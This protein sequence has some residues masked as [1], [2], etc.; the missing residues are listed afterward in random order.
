MTK[1]RKLSLHENFISTRTKITRLVQMLK[2]CF[3][4]EQT[5]E[6]IYTYS[7]SLATI[8]NRSDTDLELNLP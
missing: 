7:L 1:Q 3:E 6:I 2:E 5:T 4:L 8:Y